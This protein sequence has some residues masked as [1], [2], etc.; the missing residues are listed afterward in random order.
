MRASGE[1][2]MRGGGHRAG[3]RALWM[4][5]LADVLFIAV[6]LLVVVLGP[7]LLNVDG[8]LG[9]HLT[10]GQYILETG[11]IPTADIFSHTMSG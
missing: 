2:L 4:P 7:R 6:M 1:D 11:R 9:R 8:D 3:A 5:R 10:L